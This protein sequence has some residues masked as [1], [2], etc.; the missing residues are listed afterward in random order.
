LSPPDVVYFSLYDRVFIKYSMEM[1]DK[2]YL[3]LATAVATLLLTRYQWSRW[4]ALVVALAGAPLGLV[5][6]LLSANSVAALMSLVLGRGQSWC[7]ALSRL[8]SR[9]TL[10]PGSLMRTFA[11]CCL[12]LLLSQVR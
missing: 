5:G 11:W 3:A 12:F 8:Y 7:A 1:A 2:I 10:L 9:L 4:R 6:G